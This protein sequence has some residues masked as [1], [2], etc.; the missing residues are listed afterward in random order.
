[1]IKAIVSGACGRMGQTLVRA[2]SKTDDIKVVAALEAKDH[3]SFGK[4]IGRIVGLEKLGI[5]VVDDLNNVIEEG[6]VIIEFTNTETTLEHLR[7]AVEYNKAIVIGTTGFSEEQAKEI[8]KLAVD[9]PCVMAPNMSVGVNMLFKTVRE[10]APIL[11]DDYDIEIIEAHHRTKREAP[12]GTAMR[13]ADVLAEVLGRN[14]K[15]VGIYGRKGTI[16]ERPRKE[17]GI[18]A[19]R[20]GDIVGEHR[21]LFVTQGE[22]LEIT[23]RVH[24]RDTFARGALR[25]VRFLAK[26][27][28]GLYDMQDVL[29]LK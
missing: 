8:K 7:T 9:V 10:I 12:S 29:K 15:E 2:I 11:G 16:G 25:A 17:I 19:I 26:A 4:D 22:M 6:D 27:K 5:L 13:I 18:H 1:M 23:H 21:V 28:K 3:S 20:A 24:S 14:I